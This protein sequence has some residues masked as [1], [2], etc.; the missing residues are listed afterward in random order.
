[1]ATVYSLICWGGRLGKS[2]TVN[3]STDLVTLT[4]HGLRNG[5]G[6]AFVSGTLPTVSGTAL[7]L[8]TTYYAKSISSSTFEL[9]YETALTSKIDFTSTGASLVMKSAYLLGLSDLSRW[10]SSGSERIYDGI[11]SCA[12][13]R[14]SG[15]NAYDDE[16]IEVGESFLDIL[17]TG[18]VSFAMKSPT[19]TLA[20]IN[21]SGHNGVVDSGYIIQTA[22]TSIGSG[23]VNI[24]CPMRVIGITYK[25]TSTGGGFSLG[26]PGAIVRNCIAIGGGTGGTSYGFRGYER[27]VR[28]ENCL[29]VS[30]ARG[31]ELHTTCT[32]QVIANNTA[33]NNGVGIY[34]GYTSGLLGFFFNN[35]S[36]GNTTNWSA[37]PTGIDAA[38]KN[39]GLAGDTVWDTS[40]SKVTVATS[41]FL[42][43]A[44]NVFKP[45]LA[46][47]PQVDS[48]LEYYGIL[49][50][51]INNE[52]RPNYNNGGSVGH[53]IG[54]YEYDHGYGP[55]PAS[56]TV[57][58]QGI[59]A[60]SEIHVYDSA[61]NE[62]VGVESC[63]A[64]HALTWSIPANP[65]VIV[66]IIKRGLRWMKFSYTSE[67]GAQSLPIFQNADL[68]YNNPA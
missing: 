19:A 48:G 32:G 7:A 34:T 50:Y 36:V 11:V 60:G 59:V 26:Y 10:G 64:N 49:P 46:T 5:K 52:V 25:N 56:T 54:C 28:I 18:S 47:S 29:A 1:M 3:A 53:D 14:N 24:V 55:W 17:G 30:F 43:Y 22:S 58:F 31:F 33:T 23:N 67:A 38:S 20:P 65:V 6:V 66:T 13:A 12:S 2:V 35:L 41:D 27:L 39:A 4:N 16:Y 44:G 51:D 15:S 21:N 42:N 61:G 8:N 63:D 68:G 57:T 62:L 40:A 9:Y 37:Q 45:A